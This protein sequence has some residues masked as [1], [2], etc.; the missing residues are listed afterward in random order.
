MKITGRL[1]VSAGLLV[2]TL[3][4]LQFRVTGEA[5]PL[6][7]PLAGFPTTLGEWQARE[8]SLLDG[9]TL[10]VLRP[11]DYLVR[12]EV[13]ASARNLWLYIG[14][15]DSQRKGAQPHSPKNC[16]PGGGWEPL[17]ASTLTIPLGAGVAPLAVNRFLLQKEREQQVVLYW[18]DA[19][20]RA[21][22]GEVEAKVE[23]VRSAIFRNRTD[24]AIVRVSS[25]VYGS[26]AETTERLT[27]YVQA[28]YP[29]LHDYLPG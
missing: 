19:Q 14:Y 8:T 24:G 15:W 9:D 4:G 12:R 25:P 26:V 3:V 20:G 29:V 22:A 18:F 16:L 1:V 2:A 13:D 11:T 27:R 6:R 5:M 7:K 21:V 28:L 23:M 17:E 10:Q